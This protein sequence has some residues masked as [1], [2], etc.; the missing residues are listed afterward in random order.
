MELFN[1]IIAMLVICFFGLALAIYYDL[2]F[3]KIPNKLCLLLA[4]IG[5]CS[6]VYFNGFQGLSD[7]VMGFILAFILLFP[8]F[9][10][11][12]L[13]GGDVKLM[14]AIGFL[15]GPSL[16]MWNLAYAIVLGGLTTLL[17][18]FKETGVVGIKKTIVRYYQC[19]YL[20]KYF[21]PSQGEAAALRVPYA[22]ALALG[23]IWACSQNQ[24]VAWAVMNAKQALN[25]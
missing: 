20:R 9:A 5:I 24:D 25:F 7:G 2:R 21:K 16:L 3:H 17:L 22:P 10:I 11:K 1:Y 18:C 12:A 14:M 19:F 13:G 4:S 23:W 8:L 15:L 6:Q